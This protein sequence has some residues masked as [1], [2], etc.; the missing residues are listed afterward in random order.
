METPDQQLIECIKSS[1]NRK[2]DWALYQFYSNEKIRNW[3]RSYIQNQRG[4]QED[5][6]DVFQEAIVILDR[7]VREDRFQQASSLETYF[8]AIIKWS[9]LTYKR[10]HKP[11]SELETAQLKEVVD[12]IETELFQKERRDLINLAIGQLRE[13]CQ[14]VLGLY[15][16]DYSMK[17]I[18]SLLNISSPALAKKQAHDC[19]KQLRKV[20]LNNPGLLKALNINIANV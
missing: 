16:L 9:W 19:R 18:R 13:H 20:F 8:L 7:N 3:A 10:K 6:E 12:S 11:F 1:D 14:K 15:K 17:E 4:I 2:R 5:M